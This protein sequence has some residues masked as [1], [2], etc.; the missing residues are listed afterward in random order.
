MIDTQ[1]MHC[2]KATEVLMC[3]LLY[4]DDMFLACDTAEKLRGAVQLV[5]L[6]RCAGQS[7]LDPERQEL[8]RT[9]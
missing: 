1:L 2:E 9:T 7:A 3:F 8:S 4:V 6:Y 5:D